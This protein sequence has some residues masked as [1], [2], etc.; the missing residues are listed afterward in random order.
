MNA[1][2][3]MNNS[4]LYISPD[5]LIYN[6]MIMVSNYKPIVNIV[7]VIDKDIFLGFVDL[8]K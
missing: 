2:D 7:P 8:N 4:P 6:M 5:S 1:E 3:I